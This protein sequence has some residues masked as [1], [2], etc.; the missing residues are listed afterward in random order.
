MNTAFYCLLS[1]LAV[2]AAVNLYRTISDK[3]A[4]SRLLGI[5][6]NVLALILIATALIISFII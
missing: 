2:S 6:L 4:R 5:W 3:Q 1:A